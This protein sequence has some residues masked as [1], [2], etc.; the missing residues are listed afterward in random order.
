MQYRCAGG[1]RR[2]RAS[3]T[4]A[5]P[6]A[7]T[8]TMAGAECGIAAARAAYFDLH[9]PRGGGLHGGADLPGLQFAVSIHA[10]HA[11]RDAVAGHVHRAE[12]V[13]I[14]APHAGRGAKTR[15]SNWTVRRS[16][17]HT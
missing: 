1:S 2:G 13:S 5:S 14:H 17:E 7:G 8:T 4:A 10:P 15:P 3:A 16:E 12:L 6:Q 11:G 9:A